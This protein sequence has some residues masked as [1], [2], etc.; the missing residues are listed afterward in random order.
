LRRH[1]IGAGVKA[2]VKKKKPLFSIVYIRERLDF[3]DGRSILCMS[4]P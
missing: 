3:A 1:S 4:I 2:V